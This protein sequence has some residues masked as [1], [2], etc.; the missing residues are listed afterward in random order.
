MLGVQDVE[1]LARLHFLDR[2]LFLPH[3]MGLG[4]LL[5]SFQVGGFPLLAFALNHELHSVVHHFILLQDPLSDVFST[6]G[7]LL[8]SD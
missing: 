7:A 6:V 4:A 3:L 2:V 8:L 1:F 5:P